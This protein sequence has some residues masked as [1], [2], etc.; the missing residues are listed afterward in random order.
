[1]TIRAVVVLG[2]PC[3]KIDVKLCATHPELGQ[4]AG[5]VPR[6]LSAMITNWDV[7][8]LHSIAVFSL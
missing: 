1:M 4:P 3:F 2:M 6:T 8:L 7:F 5:L